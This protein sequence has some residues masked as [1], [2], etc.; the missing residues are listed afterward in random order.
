MYGNDQEV[1]AKVTDFSYSCIGKSDDDIVILPRSEL[2]QAPEYHR[3][4]C[5][6]KD[7]K[8]MDIYSFG[9]I[10]FWLLFPA[11]FD[12][13]A[14]TRGGLTDVQAKA[15]RLASE[16]NSSELYDSQSLVKFFAITLSTDPEARKMDWKELV[17]LLS[18]EL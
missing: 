13:L 14:S 10:C 5:K 12:D 3:G 17:S 9:L 8:L 16:K 11:E 15:E 18:Q 7:A 6:V 2:W 1:T 4:G